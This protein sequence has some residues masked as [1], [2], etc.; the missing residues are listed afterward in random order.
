[1]LTRRNLL[2]GSTVVFTLRGAS[3][4]PK[5]RIDR[6]LKGDDVD[7]T[8]FS[9]WHHFLDA[10]K[11]GEDHARSTL[12]FHDKFHTDLVKVMSDYPYPKPKAEWY[13]LREEQN[14]FPRQIT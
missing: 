13:V 3:L 9:F 10:S 6:V 5:E 11:S 7:R 8:P 4:T 14:P 1:M 2:I 12:E